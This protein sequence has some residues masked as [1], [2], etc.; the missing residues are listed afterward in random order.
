MKHLFLSALIAGFAAFGTL[1]AEDV[2]PACADKAACA[3]ACKVAGKDCTKEECA[4]ACDATAKAE[5][6]A[7]VKVAAVA[8]E[9]PAAKAAGCTACAGCGAADKKVAQVETDKPAE[10]VAK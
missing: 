3:E 5:K 1:A 7:D 8:E 10:A 2:K 9:K 6:K 4:T